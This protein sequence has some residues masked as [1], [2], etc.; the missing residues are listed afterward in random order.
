MR[1]KPKTDPVIRAA[2]RA[3]RAGSV[4]ASTALADYLD[5]QQH[6]QSQRVRDLVQNWID[7]LECSRNRDH[8]QRR[9]WTRWE[10]IASRHE[11]LR[12]NILALFGW[13]CRRMDRAE[14]YR[15]NEPIVKKEQ[16]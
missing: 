15:I 9:C 13:I 1:T 11:S 5:E 7:D 2:L 14:L 8:S 4:G 10:S 12:G 16:P 3:I 6:P